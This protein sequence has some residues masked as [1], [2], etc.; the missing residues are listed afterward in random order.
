MR[1]EH[2]NAEGAAARDVVE[3][4]EVVAETRPVEGAQ[5]DERQQAA[6]DVLRVE[7]ARSLLADEIR[8]RGPGRGDSRSRTPY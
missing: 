7:A 5:A 8:E 6:G 3:V 2:E 1:G 4:R